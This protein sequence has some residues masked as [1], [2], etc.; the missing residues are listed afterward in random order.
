[1]VDDVEKIRD[2]ISEKVGHFVYLVVGFI[3]TVGISFAYGWKLTLAVSSY[4]PLVILVN[5]YVA[6]FQGKL[7]A[8]EQE[9]YAGAGNLAEEILSA[10][11]TVVS[12]GGEKQEVER[13]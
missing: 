12:F 9:S 1:M 7:T 2:G 3:I 13:Y 4:I 8:R 11:R 5:Y 10:I 6:K